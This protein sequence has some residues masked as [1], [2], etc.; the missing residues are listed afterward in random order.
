MRFREIK[1]NGKRHTTRQHAVWTLRR[2]G[3][4]SGAKCI[5]F[6][7]SIFKY[8]LNAS[9]CVL[10]SKFAIGYSN[11]YVVFSFFFFLFCDAFSFLFFL[12]FFLRCVFSTYTYRRGSW[13]F[14]GS[15]L[16]FCCLFVVASCCLVS[17]KKK[18]KYKKEPQKFRKNTGN[19]NL[20]YREKIWKRSDK[21]QMHSIPLFSLSSTRLSQDNTNDYICWTKRERYIYI[22]RCWITIELLEECFLVSIPADWKR[23]SVVVCSWLSSIDAR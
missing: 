21:Y 3:I 23:G 12:F 13:V 7:W 2:K 6:D 8:N 10:N 17:Q 4:L 14:R 22:S 9:G 20:K 5:I 1:I 18:K 11:F 19:P 15:F 16:L